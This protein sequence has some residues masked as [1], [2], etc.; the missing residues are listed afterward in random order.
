MVRAGSIS[1]ITLTSI[2]M[3]ASSGLHAQSTG[4][5]A[6]RSQA[7]FAVFSNPTSIVV[8]DAPVSNTPPGVGSPYPSTITVTS[9]GNRLLHLQ[10]TLIN[11]NHA[12]PDDLDVLLVGPGGQKFVLQS[13]AGG[14]TA[15]VNLTYTF[16]D[17]GLTQLPN[18]GG[19]SSGTFKPA[20]HQGNDGASDVFPSPAPSGPYG[21]PGPQ[22]GGSATLNGVFGGSDPNGTWSLYVTDD[23][24]LDN[25]NINL[26]WSLSIDAVVIDPFGR[27][28]VIDFAGDGNLTCRLSAMLPATKRGM[29]IEANR[30][31][32]YKV[33]GWPM[34]GLFRRITTAMAKRISRFGVLATGTGTSF[35]ATAELY[36]SY[37]LEFQV[38]IQPL[39]M[40]T[41]AM[42]KP[43]LP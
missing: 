5:T 34:T 38:T 8:A 12:F 2:A 9:Q 27:A 36:A 43:I 7:T 29:S 15:A 4:M 22:S 25:G 1:L 11:V 6:E 26:G 37:T 17:T 32:M 16:D 14:N 35:K 10:V 18:D 13:D 24:N 30:V 21:N 3:F 33:G 23:E 42:A 28:H 20:N 40:I 39:L 19:L 31:F 41:M